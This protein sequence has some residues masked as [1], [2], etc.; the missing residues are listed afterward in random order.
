[1]AQSGGKLRQSL[2]DPMLKILTLRVYTQI[3]IY[4]TLFYHRPVLSAKFM[5][6][7]VGCTGPPPPSCDKQ[8]CCLSAVLLVLL[9]IIERLV[10]RICH[11]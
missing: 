4:L 3:V 10:L 11:G 6:L 8:H 9:R 7:T 2:I 1:M 5:E